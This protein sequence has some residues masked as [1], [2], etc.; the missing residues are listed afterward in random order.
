[1]TPDLEEN[2][3]DFF[4]VGLPDSSLLRRRLASRSSL[5]AQQFDRIL[6]F[7]AG[8]LT[9]LRDQLGSG[10]FSRVSPIAISHLL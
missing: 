9:E 6:P 5:P 3:D 10:L 7:V 4:I 1:M 2:L 8:D